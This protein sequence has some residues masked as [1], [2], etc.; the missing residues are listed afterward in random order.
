MLKWQKRIRV[1]L[2]LFGIAF[3]LMVYAAVGSRR[4]V[5]PNE[6][7]SR[8]DPRAILESA[9]AAFQQFREARQDYVIEAQRQLTYEGGATKFIGV[10]IRVRNRGGRDFVVSGRE[11]EAGDNRKEL[12]VIGDVRLVA[13]DGFTVTAERATFSEVDATVR[14]PGSVEFQ[15]GHMLGSGTGMT[16]DRDADLLTLAD[17][18]RV[19][20]TDDAGE[21][22]TEFTSGAATLSRRDHYLTLDENVHALRDKQ[23][24]EADRALAR[25]SDNDEHITFIE[26]RGN[27][28]VVGGDQFQS[29]TARDIDLDY[30]DD[31]TM[32]ERVALAESGTIVMNGVGE[33]SGR[34]FRAN[35]LE[36]T[37]AA[38]SVTRVVGSGNV[39][40]DLPGGPSVP[41]RSIA[42]QAVEATGEPG[43]DLTAA[44]FDESVEYRE[45]GGGARSRQAR[46]GV[47]QIALADDLVTSALFSGRVQFQDEGLRAS[48]AQAQYDPQKGALRLSGADA[49]GGPQVD[50]ASI[51][52]DAASIDVTLEGPQMIATGAV[53]TVLHPGTETSTV[54]GRSKAKVENPLPGLLQQGQD[55]NVNGDRLQYNSA[56]KAV[57]AGNATLWQGDTAIRADV[58]TLDQARKDLVASGAARSNIVLET[59]ASVGRAVEI[60]YDDAAR[61]I[62][63]GP[64]LPAKVTKPN[65]VAVALPTNAAQLIG[66]QGDLRAARIEVLLA[67][68][69]SRAERLEAY[70]DVRAKVDTRVATGDRLTYHADDERYVMTGVATVPVKIVEECRETSGRTVT[71]FKSAERV[72]VDGNEEIRTQSRS[73]GT[74]CAELPAH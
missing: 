61:L 47:L 5:E 68:D 36:M 7:P 38:D 48:A 69:A 54:G 26:L 31:G 34:R 74:P 71:F 6:Q 9:G 41:V 72:I 3:A 60:R 29:M 17:D 55:A 11:A 27:A 24:L 25:L 22:V 44:R 14:V 66:P 45:E 63:Y 59:G 33:D 73:G 18:A 56:G 42:A 58:I 40:V 49:G 35:S 10:T 65:P 16:Y 28:R 50:D 32:L 8:L 39:R 2:A 19:R 53:K 15:K 57:Y 37:L 4:T 43:K 23:V 21:T 62:A 13:S 64:A 1:G 70:G 52:V 20:V 67:K 46:S 30:T 12:Q 51:H